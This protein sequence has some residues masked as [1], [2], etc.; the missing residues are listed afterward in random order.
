MPPIVNLLV[1]VRRFR[2]IDLDQCLGHVSAP[3]QKPAYTPTWLRF[4][5]QPAMLNFSHGED[6]NLKLLLSELPHAFPHAGRAGEKEK[7]S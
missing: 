4:A 7:S 1:L 6:A 3:W 2:Q 5:P